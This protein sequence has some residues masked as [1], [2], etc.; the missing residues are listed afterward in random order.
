M[1]EE[2]AWTWTWTGLR[3][4]CVVAAVAGAGV[5]VA[6]GGVDEAAGSHVTGE[7]IDCSMPFPYDCP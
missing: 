4:T 7:A 6:G 1:V 3:H 2:E 5:A